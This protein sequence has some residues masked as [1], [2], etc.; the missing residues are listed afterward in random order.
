M[1][2]TSFLV[3]HLASTLIGVAKKQLF[4]K[5]T[6]QLEA[7]EDRLKNIQQAVERQQAMWLRAA[8]LFIKHGDYEKA[9]GDLVRAVASDPRAAVA[10]LI[11]GM[12]LAHKGQKSLATEHLQTALR[13]N[14]FVLFALRRARVLHSQHVSVLPTAIAHART[15]ELKRQSGC[16]FGSGANNAALVKVSCAGGNVVASWRSESD[17]M[18]TDR[19]E[20]SVSSYDLNTGECKWSTAVKHKKLVFATPMH[21]VLKST[22]SDAMYSFLSARDGR[23]EGEVNQAYLETI[24]CP[25]VA[26]TLDSEEYRRSN[27]P[28]WSA[29]EMRSKWEKEENKRYDKLTFWQKLIDSGVEHTL[30]DEETL[31][32]ILGAGLYKV[33]ATNVW[34]F[35]KETH[36][37]TDQYTQTMPYGACA[38]RLRRVS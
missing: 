27:R 23:A 15:W 13:I 29:D 12:L 19:G 24:F 20:R 37:I 25:D 9:R 35:W 31:G 21:V 14:P 8:L 10:H 3:E 6:P 17:F 1:D 36:A 18:K 7:I 4:D 28:F 32:D 5:V 2:M 11:L 16:G 38:C 26:G 22:K 34:R 30:T 33:T